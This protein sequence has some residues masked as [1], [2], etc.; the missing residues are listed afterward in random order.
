MVC[1]SSVISYSQTGCSCDWSALAS[2]SLHEQVAA[3]MSKLQP[4]SAS[5]SLHEQVEACM[6]K[7]LSSFAHNIPFVET[8]PQSLQFVFVLHRTTTRYLSFSFG[9]SQAKQYSCD[10]F[11]PSKIQNVELTLKIKR[12]TCSFRLQLSL[13]KT[14]IQIPLL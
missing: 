10:L 14:S 5:C 12:E 13:P 8:I 3:F 9:F 1:W 7:L 11:N 2:C 6:S 4:S